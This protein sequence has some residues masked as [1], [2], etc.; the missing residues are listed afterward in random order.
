MNIFINY[1][2]TYNLNILIICLVLLGF[3]SVCLKNTS[4]EKTFLG[5][6]RIA[7]KKK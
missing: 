4:H 1:Q 3:I 2:S 6:K 7:L 5:K